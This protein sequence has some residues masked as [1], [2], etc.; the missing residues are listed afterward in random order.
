MMNKD[1]Q[2]TRLYCTKTAKPT[3]KLFYLLVA[4]PF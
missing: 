4:P 2:Y 1:F 3:L